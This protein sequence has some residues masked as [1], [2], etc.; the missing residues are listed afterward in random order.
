MF[1]FEINP[2][3]MT[4]ETI[5]AMIFAAIIF[6]VVPI[7]LAIIEYRVTRKKQRTGLYIMLG[8]FASA[9]LLGLYSVFVGL[10]LLVIYY[11]ASIHSK[12]TVAQTQANE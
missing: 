11:V 6:I 5:G 9:A 1:N 2:S 10:L 7:I 3:A 8:S 4:G 12:G